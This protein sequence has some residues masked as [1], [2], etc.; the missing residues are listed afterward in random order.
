[1]SAAFLGLKRCLLQSQLIPKDSKQLICELAFIYKSVNQEPIPPTDPL[2]G[3]HKVHTLGHY[4]PVLVTEKTAISQLV[5]VMILTAQS[6]PKLLQLQSLN[7]LS[8]FPCPLLPTKTTVKAL[9][10]VFPLLLSSWLTLVLPY[11]ALSGMLCFPVSKN[12]WR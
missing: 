10:T 8:C 3:S 11:V 5:M 4:P 2:S 1:M 6:L 12:L 7:L 9:V